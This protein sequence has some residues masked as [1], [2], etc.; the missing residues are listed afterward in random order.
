MVPQKRLVARGARSAVAHLALALCGALVAFPFLWMALTSLKSQQEAF[1]YP[2]ALLPAAPHWENYRLAWEAA[3]FA[4]YFANS[5]LVAGSVTASVVVTS[6]F[7]G[8]AFGQL[9]FP[10]KHFLFMLYL[11][12]MMIPFEVVLIPNFLLINQLGWYDKYQAMIVPW[13]ANALSVFLLTQHFRSMPRE[14]REAAQVDGCG[15]WQFLTSVAAPLARPALS[16]AGLFAF[17]GSWN[18]LLWP[19]LVTKSETLRPVEVGLQVFLLEEGLRPHLLMAAS[20]M[21]MLPI[22]VLF[23]TAQRT[24]VEGVAAGIKG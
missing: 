8:Y 11:A 2:P 22:L 15:H 1:A 17:L 5:A 7:G 20:T 19:L 21:A 16:T 6:L 4:R 13:G 18:W 12:T 3:P 23:F 10:G 14:Y 9:E 24:F